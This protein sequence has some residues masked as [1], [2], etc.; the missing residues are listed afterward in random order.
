MSN[1]EKVLLK[2]A[3]TLMVY[4]YHVKENGLFHGKTG[5]ML[6]LYLYADYSKNKIVYE[7]AGNLLDG[8]MTNSGKAPSSFEYGIA[9]LGWSINK[10]L[11][12]DII[13][14]NPDKVMQPLDEQLLDLMAQDRWSPEWHELIYFADRVSESASTAEKVTNML[15]SFSKWKT[16]KQGSKLTNN[17]ESSLLYFYKY[18]LRNHNS[19]KFHAEV[20]HLLKTISSKQV[21]SLKQQIDRSTDNL[22]KEIFWEWIKNGFVSLSNSQITELCER[23]LSILQNPDIDIIPELTKNGILLSSLL[24]NKFLSHEKEFR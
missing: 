14:G 17:Q 23:S 20:S 21:L 22:S 3:N 13:G 4:V 5:I 24:T 1:I 2:I 12:A 6:Y 19:S 7:F 15:L 8:L 10:L 18:G 16:D 11:H 9:G